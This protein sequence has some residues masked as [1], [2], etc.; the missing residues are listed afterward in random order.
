YARNFKKCKAQLTASLYKFYNETIFKNKVWWSMLLESNRYGCACT[1]KTKDEKRTNCYNSVDVCLMHGT[2]RLRDTLVH[3]MC[4]AATWLINGQ[5]DG[6]GRLWQLYARTATLVHPELPTVSR[7]H[8]YNITFK[9]RYECT[10]CKNSIGRHSKSLDT[11]RFV[12]ALCQGR[13]VL[14]PPEGRDGTP[15]TSRALTPFTRFVKE[16][17]GTTRSARPDSSHADIM[18]ILGEQFSKTR[19]Q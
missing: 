18:R 3:E 15:V 14:L 9:Y 2:E 10:R 7:C 8:T 4:H 12:C 13:F 11:E 19:L 16:Q 5:R 1:S 6:H 17:Y